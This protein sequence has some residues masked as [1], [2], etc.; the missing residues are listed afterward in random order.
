M[1]K[2]RMMIGQRSVLLRRLREPDNEKLGK[3]L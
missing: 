1:F 3:R 2:E